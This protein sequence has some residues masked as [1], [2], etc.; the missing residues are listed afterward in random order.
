M[1]TAAISAVS[2]VDDVSTVVASVVIDP[3]PVVIIVSSS[4]IAAVVSVAP[5]S[6]AV[7]C[8]TVK[9]R[10]HGRHAVKYGLH[11]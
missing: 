1:T 3:A 6:L 10:F 7:T 11:H 4:V 9:A 2:A 8:V 5:V